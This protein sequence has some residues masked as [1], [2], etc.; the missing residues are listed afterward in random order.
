[1]SIENDL[2]LV[3]QAID[4][5]ENAKGIPNFIP[6]GTEEE[7]ASYLNV[8]QEELLKWDSE[9]CAAGAYFLSQY[10]IYIQKVCNKE[11]ANLKWINRK[12]AEYRCDKLESYNPYMK[13][14]HKIQLI[15]KENEVVRKLLKMQGYTEHIIERLNFIPSN[16]K[17]MADMLRSLQG[18]KR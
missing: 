2:E 16:I 10:S 15:A 14:E 12:L 5:Y 13:Y 11:S 17:H 7:L 6:P 8:G 1:M 4:D 9:D 18:A 3:N